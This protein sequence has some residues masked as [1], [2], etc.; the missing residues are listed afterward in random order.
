MDSTL[1]TGDGLTL[2]LRDWPCA[3]ARGTVLIAHGLGD[4]IGRYRHVAAHLNAWGWNAV[5]Y[6]QRGHGASEG[7]RG[8]LASSDD[9]LLDLARV[10][11]A[12][13]ATHPGP[14]VLLGHSLGGLV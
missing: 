6:D 5:G 9:L 4:H 2:R 11:D 14:L 13:R 1:K 7:P 3:G 8:Q 10:I 12:A